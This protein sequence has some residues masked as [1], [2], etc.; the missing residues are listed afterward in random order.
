MG[1]D[2]LIHPSFRFHYGGSR[3]AHRA[4]RGSFTRM[5]TWMEAMVEGNLGASWRTHGGLGPLYFVV[6]VLAWR[7]AHL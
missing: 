6:V 1:W 7:R 3:G 5:F 4:R 2:D